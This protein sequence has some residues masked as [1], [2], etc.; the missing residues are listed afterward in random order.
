M[1]GSITHL[2]YKSFHGRCFGPFYYGTYIRK[3][4]GTK[5]SKF[6]I[7]T[8]GREHRT[9]VHSTICKQLGIM[10][11]N[12]GMKQQEIKWY[13]CSTKCHDGCISELPFH[14][15]EVLV[16][17]GE[18]PGHDV[19]LAASGHEGETDSSRL[20]RVP[21]ILVIILLLHISISSCDH[22]VTNYLLSHLNWPKMIL[23]YTC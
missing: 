20:T 18:D 17:E 6:F 1:C 15:L 23:L 16:N 9:P 11:D 19:V 3:I 10:W 8:L 12:T 21:I 22:H 13:R 2:M 4:Q 7:I 14:V 5:L